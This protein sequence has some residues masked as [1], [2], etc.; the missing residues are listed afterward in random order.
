MFEA[1][2]AEMLSRKGEHLDT[3]VCFQRTCIPY[4][5]FESLLARKMCYCNYQCTCYVSTFSGWED[6]KRGHPFVL[7]AGVPVPSLHIT[8]PL[9]CRNVW[10]LPLRLSTNE[11]PT[12]YRKAFE[13]V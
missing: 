2:G 3:R 11:D 10:S 13:K 9:C 5:I 4:H 6:L 7:H 12:S 1:G 8:V